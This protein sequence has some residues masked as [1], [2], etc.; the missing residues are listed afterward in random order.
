[1]AIYYV[2]MMRSRRLP[3]QRW[4]ST[5]L[6]ALL[7][8]TVVPFVTLAGT[9]DLARANGNNGMVS[10]VDFARA[11]MWQS[12]SQ[13]LTISRSL[14]L[15]SVFVWDVSVETGDAQHDG[16]ESQP[17]ERVTVRLG[18]AEF[19]PTNDIPDSD[20]S[21]R[22]QTFPAAQQLD[23][24]EV[25]VAHAPIVAPDS[26]QV[27]LVCV[28]WSPMPPVPTTTPTTSLP[29]VI[30]TTTP[31]STTT[32]TTPPP[33]TSSNPPSATTLPPTSASTSTTALVAD[34][35][36][37]SIPPPAAGNNAPPT[38]GAKVLAFTGSSGLWLMVALA[39]ILLDVGYM[40]WSSTRSRA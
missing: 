38:E 3:H 28:T 5:G 17:G 26:V 29:P 12:P 33:T 9:A 20:P 14:D 37:E 24:T 8:A 25:T 15:G 31:V 4:P 6:I 18:T 11:K 39:V 2:R 13:P 36:A 16:R 27:G 23:I 22:T 35:T 19:G 1:V 7:V 32:T 40:V 30:S 21:F 34:P 10:C